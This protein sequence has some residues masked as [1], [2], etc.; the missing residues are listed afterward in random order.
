MFEKIPRLHFVGIFDLIGPRYYDNQSADFVAKLAEKNTGTYV[1]HKEIKAAQ[2]IKITAQGLEH[3]IAGTD[4]YVVGPEDDLEDIKNA[5]QDMRSAMSDKS[6]EG[7]CL[8]ASTL[9]SLEAL[10]ELLSI[11]VRDIRIGP[12]HKSDVMRASFM[13]ERKKEYATILAFDVKVTPE[14]RKLADEAGVKIFNADTIYD[15]SG[16]FKAYIDNLKE[17]KKKEA[18]EEA[19]FPCVLKIMPNCVFNKK[20]PIVL[21]VDVLEGIAKIGTPICIPSRNFIDIGRIASIEINHKQV[22]LA[23]KGQE[24]AI[25]IASTNAEEQQKMYGRHFEIDDELVS[26]I[27]RKSID[28]LKENYREDLS[29]EWRL[30]MKLKTLFKIQ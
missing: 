30:V 22:D 19:V 28:I 7:V 15:L 23:K 21:G 16:Q 2:G 18:A 12:V 6:I 20:D 26:H 27:T 8:K 13:L 29:I 25:K 10:L 24:V 14:A 11:P 5:A 17:E 4:L 1:H 9:G 3:A